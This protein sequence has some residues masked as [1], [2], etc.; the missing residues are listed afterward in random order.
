[1]PVELYRLEIIHKYLDLQCFRAKPCISMM[2]GFHNLF[3]EKYNI[4]KTTVD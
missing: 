3:I 4:N 1:M 2:P